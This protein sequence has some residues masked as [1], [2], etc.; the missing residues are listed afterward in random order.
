MRIVNWLKAKLKSSNTPFLSALLLI[1]CVIAWRNFPASG[2]WLTGWDNLHPEFD[3]WLNVKRAVTGVW[4]ANEGLG[5]V[6]GHGY[7][8]TLPHTL[9]LW[10]LSF[11]FPLNTLRP[12]FTFLMLLT[13]VLGAYF[14]TRY[15]LRKIQSA[16][17]SIL[18]I[19][20]FF[21]GLLYMLHLITVQNFY[22]QLEAFIVHFAFLPWLFLAL[23]QL[24]NGWTRK[25]FI[26]FILVNVLIL[27]AAFIP[28]LFI[29]Q[30]ILLGISILFWFFGRPNKERLKKI[31]FMGV[32]IFSINAFWLLPFVYYT[33]THSQNY[34]RA[35]N[36][37]QSTKDFIEKNQKYGNIKTVALGQS[38]LFEANDILSNGNLV[39][40]FLPWISHFEKPFVRAIGYFAFFFS[41]IGFTYLLLRKQRSFETHSMLA[42]YFLIFLFLATNTPPFSWFSDFLRRASPLFEQSFR[43]T[44]TKFSIGYVMGMAVFG[45]V[46]IGWIFTKLKPIWFK[47]GVFLLLFFSL[48]YYS[49]PSFSGNLIY[50]GIKTVIP[51]DYF[52]LFAYLKSQPAEGRIMNLPQ[53]WN[54][55]WSIYRWGYTGSGFLWYGIKQPILDRAF[56]VWSSYN[57]NYYWELIHALYAKDYEQFDSLVNKYNVNWVLYDPTVSPSPGGKYFFYMDDLEKYLDGNKRFSV[58]KVFGKI[59]LYEVT[60]GKSQVALHKEVANIVPSYAWNNYDQAFLDEGVYFSDSN[61]PTNYY[62]PFRSLFSNRKV[63]EKEFSISKSERGYI[64]ANNT[65][66]KL[67][68]NSKAIV[69]TNED[70]TVAVDI[71]PQF[72][73]NNLLDLTFTL[74]SPQSRMADNFPSS[75]WT[76]QYP[77]TSQL[78][79]MVGDEQ[80]KLI[81]NNIKITSETTLLLWKKVENTAYVMVGED[82][83]VGYKKISFLPEPKMVIG[84]RIEMQV[85]VPFVQGKESYNSAN[86]P[87]FFEHKSYDCEQ[88]LPD[89]QTVKEEADGKALVFSSQNSEQCFDIILPSMPQRLGYLVEIVNKNITG[90]PLQ[91]SLVNKQ[92]EK[93]DFEIVLP[94]DKTYSSSYIIIPPMQQDGMGYSLHF[95]SSSKGIDP[96]ENYLKSVRMTPIP[97]NFLTQLKFE[98]QQLNNLNFSAKSRVLVFSQ[99]YD[100]DW[101]A[102]YDSKLLKN[103]VLVNN[104]A[105]GWILPAD[106]L[107][108][109]ADSNEPKA[110]SGIL[111]IFWPQLLE[112]LGFG[113][114]GITTIAIL[115]DCY[116]VRERKKEANKLTSQ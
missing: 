114:L 63:T 4:Q 17:G 113:I 43:V 51:K 21:S 53:G 71:W 2:Q 109:T 78:T 101:F 96:A 7:A 15:L 41:L 14:L 90:K 37:L 48:I 1:V 13:G 105:N 24:L 16:E 36:N 95:S 47:S 67:L 64:I 76:I 56:D 74:F 99:A 27:P 70:Q 68:Q 61:S 22:I 5:L 52:E 104:W 102:F 103:H 31:F 34:L 59:K 28:P 54:W 58:V 65:P 25:N 55:G 26:K 87:S 80:I 33:K 97:Y 32:T 18:N 82:K 6:G 57:E 112:Y 83:I 77:K 11:F 91:F 115:L 35:Y 100:S 45:G 10:F 89:N 108:L 50:K 81:D 75:T 66:L 106:S 88:V 62:Y 98:P 92:A 30:L 73:S 69:Q 110:T 116:I 42:G 72:H 44:F 39:P 46:G 107:Q 20:S 12:I 79:L 49:L 3:F 40:L 94:A 93:T 60:G 84:E 29:V 9:F 38:F 111:L 8:A 19:V 23:W 85:Y 86:D